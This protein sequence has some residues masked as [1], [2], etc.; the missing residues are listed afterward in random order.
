MAATVISDD[1]VPY[2]TTINKNTNLLWLTA[3]I[4]LFLSAIGYIFLS[5]KKSSKTTYKYVNIDDVTTSRAHTK[6]KNKK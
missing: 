2:I 6:R 5:N 4:L 3:L 1:N